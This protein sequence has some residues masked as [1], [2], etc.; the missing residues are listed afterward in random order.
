M[1]NR[2]ELIRQVID[3]QVLRQQ[4]DVEERRRGFVHLYGVAQACAFLALK[5]GLDPELGMIAGMLHDVWRYKTGDP[6]DHATLGSAEARTILLE[7]GCFTQEE[8]DAVSQAVFHHCD[9]AAV[10]GDFDELLKDADVLQHYLYNT[11]LKLPPFGPRL[12]RILDE[13]GV[14]QV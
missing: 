4:P 11:T 13:L 9:K 12:I 2:V 10:H 6:M 1:E 8:I 7:L 3:E 5:R 14:E